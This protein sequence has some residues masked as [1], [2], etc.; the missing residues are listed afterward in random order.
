MKQTK[1]KLIASMH[2]FHKDHPTYD[3]ETLF[4]VVEDFEPDHI[5]VEIRPEDLGA[6]ISYLMQNYPFEMV[7]LSKR[8]SDQCFGFDWLGSDIEGNPIPVHYWQEKSVYKQ[9]ERELDKDP[10]FQSEELDELF[11]KQVDICKSA[12][13]TS[14]DDGRYDVITKRYYEILD[15]IIQDTKYELVTQVRERRDQ[16]INRN[17]VNFI[18]AHPGSRVALVMGA[19]H[20]AFVLKALQLNFEDGQLEI[21]SG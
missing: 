19:N 11:S 8:Y 5:G 4:Q 16:E 21:I 18:Q 6:E 10:M 13:P 9:L 20:R 7:E 15:K 1:A 17:I 2:G 12:T 14:F 3:Y